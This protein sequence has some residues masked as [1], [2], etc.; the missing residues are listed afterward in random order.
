MTKSFASRRPH[1]KNIL[2][3]FKG[4]FD[5]FWK[6]PVSVIQVCIKY[7]YSIWLVLKPKVI[8]SRMWIKW[9]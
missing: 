1:N 6:S 8:N 5:V 4:K 9:T 7:K 2:E 3:K